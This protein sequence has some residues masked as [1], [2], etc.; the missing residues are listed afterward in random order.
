METPLAL[1]ARNVIENKERIA[2]QAAL[3]EHLRSTDGSLLA[4][5]ERL[6]D[7]MRAT[8]EFARVH[9]R[10]EQNRWNRDAQNY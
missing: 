4:E 8:L 1:A 9:R 6:L 2:R 10:D 7:V 3:V 5:A